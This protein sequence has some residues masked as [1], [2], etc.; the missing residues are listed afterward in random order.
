MCETR[1]E[2]PPVRRL[3]HDL[4]I[5]LHRGQITPE[6]AWL[7]QAERE[8]GGGSRTLPAAAQVPPRPPCGSPEAEAEHAAVAAWIGEHGSA[9]L[10]GALDLHQSTVEPRRPAAAGGDGTLRPCEVGRRRRDLA[11]LAEDEGMGGTIDLVVPLGTGSVIG[12]LELRYLLRSAR[13]CMRG[14][15]YVHI[16]GPRRPAWLGEHRRIRWHDWTP[17]KVKNH[18]IIEKFIAAARMEDVS[19]LFVASCDDWLFLRPARPVEDWGAVQRGGVLSNQTRSGYW[20]RC[21]ACTR[22]VLEGARKPVL[23]YDVHTPTVQ[24]KAGWLRVDQEVAWR[25]QH[26]HAVWSLYHNV[27]GTHG[28]VLSEETH[29][30]WHAGDG[31]A[32]PGS[33]EEIERA[34]AGKLFANYNDA[35]ANSAML[36]WLA[37]RW[38]AAAPWESEIE[39]AAVEET[40]A[41]PAPAAAAARP[42]ALPT[43]LAPA[44][45]RVMGATRVLIVGSAPSAAEAV[46]WQRR[47]YCVI[48]LNNAWRLGMKDAL[49]M[50]PRDMTNLGELEKAV[51]SERRLPWHTW[52]PAIA[53]F[54]DAK[55]RGDTMMLNAVY[56]AL[57]APGVREIGLVG[58]D[59]DYA[60]PQSHFY[61]RGTADP[62][63]LG[64]DHL[65]AALERV[66]RVAR[67]RGVE[68]V[69][70]S[71][72]TRTRLPWP[73]RAYVPRRKVLCAAVN[74]AFVPFAAALIDSMLQTNPDYELHLWTTN[75]PPAALGVYPFAE[76]QVRLHQETREFSSAE[77]ER[78]H[79]NSTRFARYLDLFEDP[80]GAGID[81]A[82]LLDADALVLRSLDQ[83]EWWTRGE[84]I[85]VCRRKIE[86]RKRAVAA[87][88]VAI[89]LNARSLA[90][91]RD[92]R[93]RLAEGLPREWFRDQLLLVDCIERAE[94]QGLRCMPLGESVYRAF[95]VGPQT[96]VLLTSTE[97]KMERSHAYR[98][99]FQ[100]ATARIA[101][102]R[103]RQAA[104]AAAEAEQELT[105][106][107]A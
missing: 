40:A 79:M 10:R 20:K 47:A 11:M 105:C 83:L 67:E 12:D 6:A 103:A 99:R 2:R 90:L 37:R 59:M 14:L 62:L 43:T 82:V 26:E 3:D 17:R 80:A 102:V 52:I 86:D 101:Q 30:G 29:C 7:Q 24:S 72:H 100:A 94:A 45:A 89:N 33:V 73:R 41:R 54:G 93:D 27:A 88:T 55:H 36:A 66:W 50:Y 107:P 18:D 61:G 51:P 23:F 4:M 1:E 96:T 76:P 65:A 32:K 56:Y 77:D 15:R 21:Q 53:Q 91:L 64:D 69:N 48:A 46:E 22:I 16:I 35:G 81:F 44:P 57:S 39:T 92:Y 31:S 106:Q 28:P 70:Y 95:R 98:D 9:R 8:A 97:R 25:G 74:A 63:R 104:A 75:V 49:A 19:E 42:A 85:A 34:A 84:D 68:L 13:E 38:P 87:C 5:A 78:C 60:Q 71:T 58:C